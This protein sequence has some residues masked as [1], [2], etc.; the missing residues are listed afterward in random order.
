MRG[1]GYQGAVVNVETGWLAE[2]I[3]DERGLSL[4]EMVVTIFMIA[5]TFTALLSGLVTSFRAI[6]GNEAQVAATALG[7]ELLETMASSPWDQLGLTF[8]ST[9]PAPTDAP[10]AMF[11]SEDVVVLGDD[12]DAQLAT[13]TLVRGERTYEIQ[14]WITWDAEGDQDVKRL[15]VILTWQVGI[16]ERTLRVESLR[17]PDPAEVIDLRVAFTRL[18]S[19]L[20]VGRTEIELN[21]SSSNLESIVATIEVSDPD[22]SVVIRWTRRDG[23]IGTR[24][25]TATTDPRIRYMDA[26]P[27]NEGQFS[28]GPQ[29][30]LVLAT[31]GTGP[32]ARSA[33]NTQN[34]TF[35]YPLGIPEMEVTQG[36]DA[37]TIGL[38][39]GDV[40]LVDIDG[41]D[42]PQ[43]LPVFCVPT[44]DTASDVRV[45]VSVNGLVGADSVSGAVMLE[46]WANGNFQ[47]PIEAQFV[48]RTE[49]GANF[50]AIIPGAF[51]IDT[52]LDFRVTA[53][54]N[55]E[56]PDFDDAVVAE[57]VV[58]VR[59]AG[60][61][62][63]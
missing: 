17:A 11:E 52:K 30:F 15:T 37:P 19:S 1:I 18:E 42:E 57:R 23:S 59:D 3:C 46:W 26:I 39:D 40:Y 44:G 35:Y 16:R 43:P 10:A 6:Q 50:E 55:A 20:A 51:A 28:N 9:P 2:R 33:S 14:R 24:L 49:F 61:P 4:I 29:S 13:E 7:N 22:A 47:T 36:G 8:G 58:A 31:S 12:V 54:R 48:S 34:L 21:E 45:T 60:G 63:C 41:E 32:N 53:E 5:I 27:I 56:N 62:S 38:D 25:P